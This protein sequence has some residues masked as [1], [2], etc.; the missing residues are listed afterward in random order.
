MLIF[1]KNLAP[2]TAQQKYKLNLVGS[3]CINEEVKVAT[4]GSLRLAAGLE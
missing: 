3:F 2:I 1:E 4:F